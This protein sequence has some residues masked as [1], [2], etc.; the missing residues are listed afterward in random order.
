VAISHSATTCKSHSENT[1]EGGAHSVDGRKLLIWSIIPFIGIFFVYNI[2][3]FL[4]PL[5]DPPLFP[6]FLH[7]TPLFWT[8]IYFFVPMVFISVILLN[9]WFYMFP[10]AEGDKMFAGIFMTIIPA[11]AILQARERN[12]LN[13]LIKAVKETG[14]LF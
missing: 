4:T 6:S 11:I 1:H 12:E 8:T 13:F 7:G 14:I 9:Q 2:G 10:I 3:H 5:S